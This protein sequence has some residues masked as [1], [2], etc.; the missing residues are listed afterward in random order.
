MIRKRI[1]ALQL[2]L[3]LLAFLAPRA[4][5]GRATAP[6]VKGELLLA[7][8]SSGSVSPEPAIYGRKCQLSSLQSRGVP[9]P[10]AVSLLQAAGA[11]DLTS[12]VRLPQSAKENTH[13]K[14]AAND[15][16]KVR[17]NKK[18]PIFKD[19]ESLLSFCA[20]LSESPGVAY[21]EPNYLGS[22][23]V[24]PNDPYYTV[25]QQ[26]TYAAHGLEMAWAIETGS[27]EMIIAVIDSGV[28]LDHVDLAGN[29]SENSAEAVGSPSVDDDGNGYVDDIYGWNFVD[30]NGDV[31]DS[32]DHGTRVAGIIA[33]CGNN[34]V[35]MSGV[36]WQADLLPLKVAS[37]T[38]G[39][40]VDRVAA[41]LRYAVNRGAKVINLSLVF[42]GDSTTLKAACNAAAL[43]AV[44]V[45]AAGNDGQNF[46][47]MYPAGYNSVAS[48]AA[49]DASGELAS[50]SNSNNPGINEW[51]D[52]AAPGVDMFSAIPADMYNREQGRGTS[53]ASPFVAGIAALLC[54]EYPDQSPAAIRNH[55]EQ[56]AS[57]RESIVTHGIIDASNALSTS[58]ETDL[59]IASVEVLEVTSSN[60]DEALDPGETAKVTIEIENVGADMLEPKVAT[61]S[62]LGS[63]IT[64]LD[65]TSLLTALAHGESSRRLLE[66]YE[67]E[68]TSPTTQV[69]VSMELDVDGIQTLSFP[70]RI[71]EKASM[72][73]SI[74]SN[75]TLTSS[76][77][78][79]V[80]GIT[81]V[82]HSATL[83][84]QPGTTV[85]F[86][87]DA[88]LEVFGTLSSVGTNANPI[89]W[90]NKTPP[91][92]SFFAPSFDLHVGDNPTSVA[93]GD[94][95]GDGL[96]DIVTAHYSGDDVSVLASDGAGGFK[97]EVRFA[98]GDRPESVALGD[99][100]GDGIPDII[101]CNYSSDDV[102]VLA[103]DGAGGFIAHATFAVGD[104]PYS[105]AL[106]D[107]TDDGVV[108]IVTANRRSDNVSVLAGDG[109]GGFV[110]D[111]TCAVGDDPR[112]VALGDV[113]GDGVVDIVTAN[114]ADVMQSAFD[115]SVLAGDGAG[116]F[117]PDVTYTVGASTRCVALG[118]VTGDGKPDIV[119]ANWASEEVSVLEADGSGGFISHV[120]Y[121]VGDHP[122][123]VALGDV[124]GDGFPD[125]V[126]ANYY[127]YDVS[128]LAGDG[129]GGFSP[130]VCFTVGIKPVSVALGDVTGDGV[131]DIVTA[132]LDSDYLSILVG[133]RLQAFVPDTKNY[134]VGDSPLGVALG[135]VTGDGLPDIVV[136]NYGPS[137]NTGT[138]DNI[139][140]LAGDGSGNFAPGVY[141]GV[142]NGPYD[143]ALGDVTGDGIIDIVTAN[144]NSDDVS[145]LAGNGAGSFAPQV[146]YTVGLNHTPT[147]VA[148]GDVTC[149]G[150]PDIVTAGYMRSE[151]SILAGDG[152]G[153]FAPEVRYDIGTY[154]AMALGDV[155]GDG[156][157]D[158]VTANESD[159]VSVRV[160][161]GS[162]GFLPEVRYPA[163]D[164]CHDVAVGDLSGDGIPDIVTANDG[165]DDVSVLV[166]DG[167]GGFAPQVRFAVGHGPA[168]VALGDAAGNG[169]LDI[170]T[171]NHW[172]GAV[173]VLASDG[174]GGFAPVVNYYDVGDYPLSV[175]LGDITG[176]GVPGIVTANYYGDDVS[177]LAGDGAGGFG[178]QPSISAKP[179]SQV[180]VEYSQFILPGPFLVEGSGT[181]EECLFKDTAGTGLAV[182]GNVSVQDSTAENCLAGFT[183]SATAPTPWDLRAL[184]N[185]SVG[186]IAYD[187]TSIRVINS[188]QQ[189]IISFG[190][191][192]G[193]T[194]DLN[195]GVGLFAFETI[196]NSIATRSSSHG[197]WGATV[198]NSFA[199]S[200]LGTGIIASERITGCTAIS[201]ATGVQAPFVENTF[202]IDSYGEGLVSV[203]DAIRLEMQENYSISSDEVQFATSILANNQDQVLINTVSGMYIAGNEGGGVDGIPVVDST[204]IGNNGAGVANN[205][206]VNSSNVAFNKGYGVVGG[207]VDGSFLMGN[208][209]GDLYSATETNPQI[210]P[211]TTAPAFL[212]EVT[213][214]RYTKLGPGIHTFTLKF[215]KPMNTGVIPTLTH[216]QSP[217]YTSKVFQN[218]SWI[219]AQEL[220]AKTYIDFN[221]GDG[222]HHLRVMGAMASD[223][224]EIPPDTYHSFQ[225]DIEG[226]KVISNGRVVEVF[227][228][229]L[230]LQWDPAEDVDLSGYDVVR[231][232]D[233]DSNYAL[234]ES[235]VAPAT[236]YLDVGLVSGVTYYY[237]I[238]EYD[239]MFSRNGLTSPFSGRP[240]TP[241]PT[242][243]ATPTST[244]TPTHTPTITPTPTVNP[245][246]IWVDFNYSGTEVGTESA[247][248]N[249]LGE[250]VNA[251]VPGGTVR[252][253]AGVTGEVLDIT[254][255]VR[256]EAPEGEARI[257]V[258]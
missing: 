233:S 15:V 98:V 37:A 236:Q 84:V 202:I 114:Y 143:V 149:D 106:G 101:T 159:D 22:L 5:A 249:T 3:V 67:I 226:G 220:Q 148:L 50:F 230:R 92:K 137:P 171:A 250:G 147:S 56:A 258:D 100:S 119:T 88:R 244:P 25:S 99:V 124:T 146:R 39:I 72:P 95:T 252:I 97:P 107:V 127:T 85:K 131:P 111:A 241:T 166:S 215:S 165:S 180:S 57:A 54:A 235:I 247:P 120:T 232:L 156:A 26:A 151:V 194:A 173:S 10:K 77:T 246:L 13:S 62:S 27:P 82:T 43:T 138:D 121:T 89:K 117:I 218:A 162:G 163:G 34:S 58:M 224:F 42:S 237:Q 210:S 81:S 49:L 103:G 76:K 191:L 251:V 1:I 79:M 7:L 110:A 136:A 28:D 160:N 125:I 116:G 135:D 51:V 142:G 87:E 40:T 47:P 113:T 229:S 68:A 139:S 31:E 140:V 167:A 198:E 239:T 41:A 184:N 253:K 196:G 60:F 245:S 141:F 96:P 75:L 182:L 69:D 214:D 221:S 164:C 30:N 228:D 158:I 206:S 257:G 178:N 222:E 175:A 190:T 20:Q 177:V 150:T 2:T 6:Y 223:G 193:V 133:E 8:Q 240:F 11:V 90:M 248:F 188:K 16:Y 63:E 108:D 53:L 64:I 74:T 212:Y 243:T 44:V 48:V 132:N 24:V 219:N 168:S 208:E 170:V 192:S 61:L 9:I 211:V 155:T 52:F 176:G 254:K 234:I 123:S 128:V 59:Q 255:E 183:F 134:S 185:R 86:E 12:V 73:Q 217:P 181:I 197:I 33:A 227:L 70:L 161:D 35:G 129:A 242:S 91:P 21:A 71:E 83:T 105:V 112:S 4:G 17:F 174:A 189:G 19:R 104:G 225:V 216:G 122:Y 256:L 32:G 23:C 209:L 66:A 145:I 238:W 93:L 29:L 144:R 36:C 80:S 154:P 187:A 18:T 199:G 207:T 126:T 102:S 46:V 201:N 118:D 55:L 94:V 109:A 115:V 179:S 205:L 153:G 186:L 200:N 204:I 38:G 213:P 195:R 172:R 78:W 14:A 203:T 157:L 169:S 231:S 130:Q 152:A 65:A 45:A